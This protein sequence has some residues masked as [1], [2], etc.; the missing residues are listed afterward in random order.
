MQSLKL[1]CQHPVHKLSLT[2][3]NF[4]HNSWESTIS[5]V[6]STEIEKKKKKKTH[7]QKKEC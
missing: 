1:L 4:W 6:I 2:Q 3:R 7:I 5:K